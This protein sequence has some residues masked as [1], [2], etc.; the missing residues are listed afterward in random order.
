MPKDL[1]AS[2]P[3]GGVSHG[4]DQSPVDGLDS[5][6]RQLMGLLMN[7]EGLEA[8]TTTAAEAGSSEQGGP[9]DL[10]AEGEVGDG[11]RGW[12]IS[13]VEGIEMRRLE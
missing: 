1:H 13:E 10:A 12:L 2:L 3:E 4:S 11:G 7:P 8:T 6:I 5:M 9:S